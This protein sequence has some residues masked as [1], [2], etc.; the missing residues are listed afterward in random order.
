MGPSSQTQAAKL[1]GVGG[2][3]TLLSPV[4]PTT[5]PSPPPE[6]SA[7]PLN[8]QLMWAANRTGK[9]VFLGKLTASAPLALATALPPR[10][11]S[12]QILGQNPWGTDSWTRGQ[13]DEGRRRTAQPGA[14]TLGRSTLGLL[15]FLCKHRTG[16]ITPK[17]SP[18]LKFLPPYSTPGPAL[19][20]LRC[21]RAPRTKDS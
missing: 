16:K 17:K 4:H 7:P 11:G 8:P 19:T 13:L 18:S 1:G 14:L 9:L 2:S 6:S 15:A 21:R 3:G 10:L 5:T 12:P 20:G